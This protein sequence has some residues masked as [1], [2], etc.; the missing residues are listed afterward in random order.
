MENSEEIL[1]LEDMIDVL[2]QASQLLDHT[3]IAEYWGTLCEARRM[4]R[5]QFTPPEIMQLLDQEIEKCY[6]S[7]KTEYIQ[8]TKKV[9]ESTWTTYC[10]L[11]K[12]K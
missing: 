3:G 9:K 1:E 5:G 12:K 6:N 8:Y 7:F 11:E 2:I 4:L 10:I